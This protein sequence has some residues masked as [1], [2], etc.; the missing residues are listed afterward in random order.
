MA[1]RS[2]PHM[3]GL[4]AFSPCADWYAVL[5]PAHAGVTR[6]LQNRRKRLQT[7]PRTCGGYPVATLIDTL[8]LHS[9]PHM[10]GLPGRAGSASGR[11]HLVPAHAGVT[12]DQVLL[13]PLRVPRPRTCGGYPTRMESYKSAQD[14]SPHMRGLPDAIMKARDEM[15]LVPAHAG[16]TSPP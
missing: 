3:R 5:V 8:G 1:G 6:H 9:S 14:S 12:R 13:G 16:V 15:G 7:R 2:S 4:P 11:E 10:R